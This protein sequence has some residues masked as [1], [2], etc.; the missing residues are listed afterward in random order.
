MPQANSTRSGPEGAQG[1]LGCTALSLSFSFYSVS[2]SSIFDLIEVAYGKV[3]LQAHREDR[4]QKEKG[5]TVR[6]PGFVQG[7][8][9]KGFCNRNG[10]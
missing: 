1:V 9:L 3:P 2:L 4:M 7:A 10:I 8:M 5:A 6:V